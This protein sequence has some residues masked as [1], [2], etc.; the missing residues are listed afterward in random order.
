MA[1]I[2]QSRPDSGLGFY[3]QVKYFCVEQ[4]PPRRRR[5]VRHHAEGPRPQR[6]LTVPSPPPNTAHIRQSSPD[7]GPGFHAEPCKLVFHSTAQK[8]RVT[9]HTFISHKVFVKLFC[10]SQFHVWHH[11][12]RPRPQRRLKVRIRFVCCLHKI[13]SYGCSCVCFAHETPPPPRTTVGP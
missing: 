13:C 3:A 5:H 11:P 4:E 2:R 9:F 8:L 7:S 6:R 1:H 12:K 10:K